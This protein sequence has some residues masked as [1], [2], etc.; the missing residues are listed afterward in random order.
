MQP[1]VLENEIGPGYQLRNRRSQDQTKKEDES[2]SFR[3]LLREEGIEDPELEKRLLQLVVA[4][5]ARSSVH[6]RYMWELALRPHAL[7]W[8]EFDLFLTQW[9]KNPRP[10]TIATWINEHARNRNVSAD[11]VEDELFEAIRNRRNNLLSKAAGTSPINEHEECLRQT[12]LLLKVMKQFLH[13]PGKLSAPRFKEIYDQFGYWIAFRKNKSD[14]MARENEERMLMG[15]LSAVSGELAPQILEHILPRSYDFYI[16]GD[17]SRSMRDALRERCLEKLAP[18]AAKESLRFFL[19]KDGIRTLTE[20]GRFLGIKYCLF[21]SQSPIRTG[22]LRTTFLA[23]ILRGLRKWDIYNNIIDYFQFLV[24]A[25]TQG[26][27]EDFIQASE[28]QVLV[29]DT[30]FIRRLWTVVVSR[31]IQY[32]MQMRFIEDRQALISLGADETAL[33]MPAV[34]TTRLAEEQAR[35]SNPIQA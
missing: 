24:R 2:E 20:P 22:K 26:S 8:K 5:R 14:Q 12:K 33:P 9:R 31:E 15:L 34:L 10:E 1:N 28:I 25:A 29:K 17:G 35:N 13:E 6:V 27:G 3:Q 18:K 16:G 21:D 23:L 32:R 4:A 7:T 11:E 19:R 30:E